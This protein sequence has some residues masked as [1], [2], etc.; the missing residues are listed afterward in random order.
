M[1]ARLTSL[2][3]FDE[4]APRCYI[5][6]ADSLPGLA[7]HEG[8]FCLV[9]KTDELILYPMSFSEVVLAKGGALLV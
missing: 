4:D 8:I 6:A 1:K 3:H 5:I 9:G 7:I 2:K